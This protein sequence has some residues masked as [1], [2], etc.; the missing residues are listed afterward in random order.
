M[1]LAYGTGKL[2]ASLREI[3]E[4]GRE[5][6]A[7]SRRCLVGGGAKGVKKLVVPPAIWT[8]HISHPVSS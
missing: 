5:N 3:T 1:F 7:G 4:F 2:M 8:S 6:N